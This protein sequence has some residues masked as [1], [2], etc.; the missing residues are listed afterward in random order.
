MKQAEKKHSSLELKDS[1]LHP[2]GLVESE[3]FKVG[4][5]TRNGFPLGW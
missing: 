2:G 5:I 1:P 4:R 3:R